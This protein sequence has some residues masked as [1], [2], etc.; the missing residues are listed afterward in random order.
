MTPGFGG[1]RGAVL[2]WP[3]E[4]TALNDL[5]YWVAFNRIPGIGRVR[6]SLLLKHFGALKQAWQANA[7]ELRAAGLED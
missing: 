7:A 2:E 5:E 6:Y 3:A 4:M 1:C